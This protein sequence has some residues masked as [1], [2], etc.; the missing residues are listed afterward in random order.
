[1][2]SCYD[3]QMMIEQRLA[4]LGLVL[5]EPMKLPPGLALPFPWVR[6]HGDRA[7]V[8]GQHALSAGVAM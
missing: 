4:E 3:R 7:Y 5:P 6:V 1:M 2:E 8:P